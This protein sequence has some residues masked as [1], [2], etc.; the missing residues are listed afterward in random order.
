MTDD[1]RPDDDREPTDDAAVAPIDD[2]ITLAS[3]YLDDEATRDERA[4]VETDPDALEA[5]ER[6]R[7]VRTVLSASTEPP[8]L[9]EREGH[10]AAA[11]D[12]WERT[13]EG[14]GER[15]PGRGLDA[16]AA[17]AVTRAAERPRRRRRG[18]PS[19]LLGAAAALVVTLGAGAVLVGLQRGGSD[20][21]SASSAGETAA[22][23]VADAAEERVAAELR[24][25]DVAD[26][27]DPDSDLSSRAEVGV[28]GESSAEDGPT[29]D[30]ESSSAATDAMTEGTTSSGGAPGD[31]ATA[32]LTSAPPAEAALVVLEGPADLAAFAAPA[33]RAAAG[34]GGASA[35]S[36]VDDACLDELGLDRIV[37][38]AIYRDDEVTVG[39]DL[40]RDRAV[41]YRTP[42]CAVVA[43]APLPDEG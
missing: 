34:D 20:D 30:G 18:G 42:E 27:I 40:G 17:S 29:A 5:V 22:T 19:W 21:G 31:E 24:G 4:L 41:A 12:V 11:L 3:T 35:A 43:T 7:L 8:S 9:S 16:V 37:D 25:D 28:A 39:L 26:T 32:G 1:H 36:E 15:T 38:V 33:A 6:F 10:L 23:A 2:P 14:A 13:T